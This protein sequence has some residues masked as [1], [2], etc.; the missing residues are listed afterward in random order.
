MLIADALVLMCVFS[1]EPAVTFTWGWPLIYFTL[2]VAIVFGL[3]EIRDAIKKD[4][5]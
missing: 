1:S 4:R 2:G 3:Q 5:E